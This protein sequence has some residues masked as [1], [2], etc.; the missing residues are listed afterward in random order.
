MRSIS[1][2]E[3][4]RRNGSTIQ[5]RSSSLAP[6]SLERKR[7]RARS[8]INFVN[9]RSLNYYPNPALSSIYFQEKDNTFNS[10]EDIWHKLR[11]TMKLLK[12]WL[13]KSL[14]HERVENP[15][16]PAK[17]FMPFGSRAW[18]TADQ[19]LVDVGSRTIT[20]WDCTYERA[21]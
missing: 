10:K 18:E 11:T 13:N 4:V 14:R 20:Q 15:G 9:P 12:K 7:A 16:N 5:Q 17:G 1:F 2:N 19:L 8:A 3:I 21:R 6:S